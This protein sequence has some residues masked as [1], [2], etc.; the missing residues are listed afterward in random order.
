MQLGGLEVARKG[1]SATEAYTVY[2]TDAI[3]RVMRREDLRGH[4][5]AILSRVEP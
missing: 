3:P 5:V 2:A 4:E 1:T